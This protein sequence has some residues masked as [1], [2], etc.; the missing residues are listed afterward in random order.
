MPKI[1]ILGIRGIPAKY[2]GFETFAEELAIRLVKRDIEVTVFCEDTGRE[3]E[4]SY[5]GVQ[6][7]YIKSPKIGPLSRGFYELKGIWAARKNFDVVYVLGYGSSVFCIIP[8]IWG[9]RVWINMDGIEWS[10]AKWSG[11]LTKLILKILEACA[12]WTPNMLIADSKEIKNFLQNR[13]SH[14]PPC[15]VI[16]YGAPIIDVPPDKNLISKWEIEEKKYYVVVCRLEPENH[17]EE[18][19]GGY[20]K[21]N[22]SFPLIVVGNYNLNTK[23]VKKLLSL[24]DKNT[25]FVG[26]V[27]KKELLKALRY[28]SFAYFHGHSVGGTNPSLLEALGCGNVIIA[29]DN[30]FNR[31]VADDSAVYFSSP[32]EIAEIISSLESGKINFNPEKAKDRIRNIYNWDSIANRYYNLIGCEVKSKQTAG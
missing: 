27:Y 31:E 11:S 22:S 29:H 19:I 18:I 23:Y 13:Y 32:N 16:E 3:K 25:R 4:N 14:I 5:K 28:Y 21:S 10:R 8:R 30:P 15:N 9:S 17:V 1:A 20:K 26:A 7:R 24:G 6:L 12:M 2:G